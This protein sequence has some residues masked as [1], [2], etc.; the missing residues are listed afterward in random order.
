MRASTSRLWRCASRRVL[1]AKACR[2][3]CSLGEPQPGLGSSPHP[4]ASD[5]KTWCR[6]AAEAAARLAD[7][8]GGGAACGVL[9]PEPQVARQRRGRRRV[10]RDQPL[11]AVLAGGRQHLSR[12]VEVAGV[13][14][15]CFSAADAFPQGPQPVA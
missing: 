2:K 3:S 7:E 15:E 12:D 13:Q 11:P 1:T 6:V 4:A 9:P 10:Q 14:G 5:R 8:Q